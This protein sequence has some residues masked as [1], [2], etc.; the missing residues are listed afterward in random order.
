MSIGGTS[1]ASPQVAGVAALYLQSRPRLTP[2]QL[3]DVMNTDSKSVIYETVNNDSDYRSFTTSIM[4]SPNRHLYSK[5]G[6]LN[7]F[8]ISTQAVSTTYNI[9][10]TNNGSS[11]YVLSGS[12]RNGAV[13][14]ND[15]TIE[16]LV[17][18]VIEFGLSVSGHPF[19]IKT[20][21]VTGTGSAVSTGVTNNGQQSG[22]CTWDTTG[23]TPGTYY[24][25]CQFHGSM[26][27]QIIIGTE[28]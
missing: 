4:G 15:P 17:G 19:W 26:V 22:T 3:K 12:D 24:Y 2:A 16:F 27:G 18:D 8:T 7:P 23:V 21:A 10:V 28:E 6:V 5:Y 9:S 11:D 13:S 20:S 25:I 1:M 14:G